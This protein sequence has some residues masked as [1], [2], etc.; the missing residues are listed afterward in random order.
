M[1]ELKDKINLKDDYF[2]K[3]ELDN[4]V[5]GFGGGTILE[6][7]IGDKVDIEEETNNQ[8]IKKGKKAT[9]KIFS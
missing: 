2:E 6:G 4:R 9:C 7:E 5:G 3:E 1:N 8:L